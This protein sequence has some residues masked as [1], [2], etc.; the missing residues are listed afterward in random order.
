MLSPRLLMHLT[1]DE[2]LDENS[3]PSS[4]ALPVTVGGTGRAVDGVSV[5][6]SSVILTLGS[7]V[8]SEDTVTVSHDPNEIHELAEL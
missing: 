3:E 4:D 2:D 6:G 8:T 5:S 7:A 1:Y